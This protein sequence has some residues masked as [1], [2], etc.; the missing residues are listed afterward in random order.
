ML[1][2][3]HTT[4]EPHVVETLRGLSAEEAAARA[5]ADGPNE[6]PGA[7][8]PG[9]RDAVREVF[10]EPM[11]LLLLGCGALYF[12]MRDWQEGV[13]MLSFV[14]VIMAIECVQ[15]RKTERALE[16]LRDL[17]SPRALVI[18]DGV[19]TRIAGRDVVRGDI[20]LLSEGDRVPADAELLY[21]VNLLVDE[22]LLT[23][24][25][26]PVMKRPAPAGRAEDACVYSGT[27]VA[28][29][30]G[31]ARVTAI[32]AATKLGGI[33]KALAGVAGERTPRQCELQQVVTKVSI[34]ALL[35]C[36]LVILLYIITRGEWRQAFLSGITLAMAM[37]PEE[38]PVVFTVFMALGAWRIAKHNVLARRLPAVE[39]LGA[40]TVLCSDKTGTITQN[41]MRVQALC[42]NG[43]VLELSDGPGRQLPEAFHELV[44][45]ALLASPPDPFDPMER[46]VKTLGEYAL[47]RTEH[48]HE[49]WHLVREYPL[50]PALL[51]M[52]R[53]WQSP[54]GA[55]YVIAAKG[56]PEAM[57]DL[58]HVSREVHAAIAAH[59]DAL[60]SRGLRVLG[61]AR[62]LFSPRD[63]PG[64]QHDFHFEW[65]GLIGL[66]DPVRAGVPAAVLQCAEAGIRVIMITGDYPATA[67]H[68]ARQIGLPHA[69][70]CVTG[71][72]LDALDDE[73]LRARL[74]NTSICARVAPEQKLRIVRALKANHEIVAMTGDGVN[75]APALKAAHIGI[76]M[77]GRGTDVA[78]EAAALVLTDDDFS[79]IVTAIRMGR[80]I[81]DNLCK[82]IAYIIAV[83]VPIAGLSLIPALLGFPP[84]LLPVHVVFLELVIDPA[85]SIA[86]EAEADERGIMRRPPRPATESLFS[87]R[88]VLISLVQGLAV[89]GMLLAVYAL[90]VQLRRTEAEIRALVFTTLIVAN[91][92][93][94]LTN[95]SWSRSIFAS[96]RTR[97][98]A[99]AAV[100]AGALFFL[101]LVL[102]A[103]FLRA[104]FKF[105]V[106]HG[107]DLAICAGAGMLAIVW[108]ECA[109]YVR[110]R[111]IT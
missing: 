26:V 55:E 1:T 29:G 102:Y 38:F 101:G 92:G 63:L 99:A 25:S 6:L 44:E 13:I 3:A 88:T 68:I 95:R 48:L 108:F 58:C 70:Q 40:T 8:R 106:L 75:D 39:T 32:G 43:V 53:V 56:A 64:G 31:I 67:F 107:V 4:F 41:T 34:A 24:E 18:R 2:Q 105:D 66:S 80:R 79:S 33:G 50:S 78:R 10:T 23:G 73:A 37:L 52:S 85:C 59:V 45:Y 71:A 49:D 7:T 15:K 62:A 61:V 90:A 94:I 103:P 60:A 57:M 96:F 42:A 93:L 19:Q 86:F 72:E 47:A 109:K 28:G 77:G 20:L 104:L 65:L 27:L 97:N 9:L 84:L 30:R 82:A 81:F 46:A 100:V 111:H 51:A 89:L 91:T 12:S 36:M 16:A 17:S 87:T 11:F 14:L 83:H 110:R 22:S 76:A 35:L 98:T 74:R 21:S 69:A 5:R 54:T